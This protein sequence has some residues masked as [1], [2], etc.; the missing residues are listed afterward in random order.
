[1]YAVQSQLDELNDSLLEAMLLADAG[2]NRE[3]AIDAVRGCSARLD[4][5]LASAPKS[6]GLLHHSY[7]ARNLRRDCDAE[8]ACLTH[9]VRG[10]RSRF[11]HIIG[12]MEVLETGVAPSLR[13]TQDYSWPVTAAPL[14]DAAGVVSVAAGIVGVCRDAEYDNDVIGSDSAVEETGPAADETIPLEEA[15][16]PVFSEE[17]DPLAEAITPSQKPADPVSEPADLIPEPLDIIPEPTDHA[18]EEPGDTDSVPN[19]DAG[20]DRSLDTETVNGDGFSTAPTS[21]TNSHR[22]VMEKMEKT[23]GPTNHHQPNNKSEET[24]ARGKARDGS[25]RSSAEHGRSRQLSFASI[26][27]SSFADKIIDDDDDDERNEDANDSSRTK[28]GAAVEAFDSLISRTKKAL[29]SSPKTKEEPAMAERRKSFRNLA[30][31]FMQRGKA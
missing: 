24:L 4:D 6:H 30:K 11:R 23:E 5:M 3:A 13:R 15:A 26:P 18:A 31:K 17:I 25:P 12:Q 27:Y 8:L 14:A 7:I 10:T 20:S 9:K 28:A 16:D 22:G 29:V 1:M 21:P 19:S 2:V